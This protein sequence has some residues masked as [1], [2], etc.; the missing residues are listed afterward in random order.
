MSVLRAPCIHRHYEPH[1]FYSPE[2]PH[3]NT[4]IRQTR[5]PCPGGRA[6]T[7]EELLRMAAS[8]SDGPSGVTDR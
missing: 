3:A 8:W 2:L 4:D 1:M 6:V 7:D 5:V